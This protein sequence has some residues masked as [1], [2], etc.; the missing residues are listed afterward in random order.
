MRIAVFA[1]ALLLSTS[2]FAQ[3][4]CRCVNGQA[5]PVCRSP[6][7]LKPMCIEVCPLAPLGLP[8]MG[9]QPLPPLGTSSCRSVQIL[10]PNTGLYEWRTVCS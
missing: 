6:L 8:P 4:V 5:Q 7:D 9:L 3:C 1:A 2:A 10:N